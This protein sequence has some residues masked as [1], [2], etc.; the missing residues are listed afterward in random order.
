VR[1][2]ILVLHAELGS[3]LACV[4]FLFHQF[5][6]LIRN[7]KSKAKVIA[8]LSIKLNNP[9][10]VLLPNCMPSFMTAVTFLHLMFQAIIRS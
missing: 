2:K 9:G 4:I 6:G 7:H 3:G 1:G 8:M 10:Y 5:P